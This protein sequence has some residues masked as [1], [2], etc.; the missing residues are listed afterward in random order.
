LEIFPLVVSGRW[1]HAPLFF[2]FLFIARIHLD[3]AQLD[4]Y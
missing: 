3:Y 1:C 2:D 4:L